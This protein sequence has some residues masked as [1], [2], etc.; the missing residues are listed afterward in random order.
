[1]KSWTSPG[2]RSKWSGCAGHCTPIPRSVWTCPPR[3]RRWSRR[4]LPCRLKQML[5]DSTNSVVAMR[6]GSAFMVWVIGT[7]GSDALPHLARDPIPAARAI[8]LGLQTLESRKVDVTDPVVLSDYLIHAGSTFNVIPAEATWQG[9]FR[10]FSPAQREQMLQPVSQLCTAM[11]DAPHVAVEVTWGAESTVTV[12]DTGPGRIRDPDR[13][14]PIRTGP[15]PEPTPP[16]RRRR[17]FLE[18]AGGGARCL[19]LLGDRVPRNMAAPTTPRTSPL[20]RACC[21][22]ARDSW[23]SWPCAG[24]GM[25]TKTSPPAAPGTA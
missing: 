15:G 23:P 10:T 17:G 24:C 22:I 4:S 8:V 25:P 2:C 7:G 11:G 5:G 12:N 20:T 3:R 21:S 6:R 1:M 16:A 19:F 18:G 13:D 9:T 14:R